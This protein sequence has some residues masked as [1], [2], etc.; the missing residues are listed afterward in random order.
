MYVTYEYY[1]NEYCFNN[2]ELKEEQFPYYESKA[3]NIIK[4][5]TLS[6]SEEFTEEDVLRTC[7]CELIDL[8]F[9]YDNDEKFNKGSSVGISS[10]KVG[11]YSVSYNGPTIKETK[12][13]KS[14]EV[15]DIVNKYLGPYGLL[16][17]G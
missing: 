10:E 1:L 14:K 2:T 5:K 17:R 3:R 12:D 9:K 13:M 4:N 8:L 7:T 16:F 15:S 11:E 6:R